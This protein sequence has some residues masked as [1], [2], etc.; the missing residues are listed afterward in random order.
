MET[1]VVVVIMVVVVVM[2]A[3]EVVMAVLTV[4]PIEEVLADIYSS[5]LT[6]I[7]FCNLDP[8]SERV[9]DESPDIWIVLSSSTSTSSSNIALRSWRNW[10]NLELSRIESPGKKPR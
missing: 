5:S 6:C 8:A 10:K 9:S 3:A 4:S 1:V 7:F 2:M